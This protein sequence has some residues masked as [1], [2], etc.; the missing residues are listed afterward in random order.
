MDQ[1]SL[2]C[3]GCINSEEITGDPSNL[4]LSTFCYVL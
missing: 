3:E 1:A 2:G 4:I